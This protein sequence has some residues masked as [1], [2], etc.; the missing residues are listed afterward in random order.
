LSKQGR[1]SRRLFGR[2][3]GMSHIRIWIPEERKVEIS[4]DVKFMELNFYLIEENET[5]VGTPGRRT[6][7]Y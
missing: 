1:N 3:G 6:R 7:N 5:D 4:S 2:I